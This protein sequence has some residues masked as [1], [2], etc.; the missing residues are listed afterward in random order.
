MGGASRTPK[1]PLTTGHEVVLA[2]MIEREEPSSKY[3]AEDA[4]ASLLQGPALTAGFM[5]DNTCEG[6]RGHHRD[7]NKGANE[8]VSSSSGASTLSKVLHVRNIA[9]A[10]T[11]VGY[12]QRM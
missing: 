7:A 8:D 6:M 10:T 4:S 5:R 1:G 12:F 11:E 2:R 3:Q 9:P